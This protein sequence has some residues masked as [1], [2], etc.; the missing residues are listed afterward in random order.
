MDETCQ[1][2][3]AAHRQRGIASAAPITTAE[4]APAMLR[5]PR[6]APIIEPVAPAEIPD[7]PPGS[8]PPA[9]LTLSWTPVS[10]IEVITKL[11]SFKVRDGWHFWSGDPVAVWTNCRDLRTAEPRFSDSSFSSRSTYGWFLE[12]DHSNGNWWCLE[13]NVPYLDADRR[14]LRRVRLGYPVPILVQ[15]F[16]RLKGP[17]STENNTRGLDADASKPIDAGRT[18]SSNPIED[19][20]RTPSSS[21]RAPRI[22]QLA[23]TAEPAD[24]VEPDIPLALPQGD[25]Q[26]AVSGQDVDLTPE[27]SSFDLGRCLTALR[28]GEKHI[29]IRAIQRLHIRWWHCSSERLTALLKSAGVSQDVIKLVPNV[30]SSCKVCRAWTKPTNR[31]VTSSRLSERFG[32]V[33]QVDLLF[34]ES[35]VIVHMIDEATRWSVAEIIESRQAENILRCITDRWIRIFGPMTTLMSDQEGGLV[36]EQASIWAER[37]SIALRFKPKGSHAAIV[38][39]HHQTIRDLYHKLSTQAQHE[40]LTVEPSDILSEAVFAKNVLTNVGGYSPFQALFGRF[41]AVLTDL[42]TAGQSAVDDTSGGIPGASRHAVRLRELAT[43]AMIGA[44]AQARMQIAENSKSRAAGQLH[45]LQPGDAVDV[46]RVPAQKDLSGWRGPAEVLSVRNID[47]GVVDIKWGGRTMS[48]RVQDIRRSALLV[49]FINDGGPQIQCLRQF[50]LQL[51]HGIHTLAWLSLETGWQLS[52]AATEHP[53]E[54]QAVL[55]T[56]ANDLGIRRCI[57]A[58]LGR[59][60]HTLGGLQQVVTSY[61]MWWPAGKPQLYQLLQHAG[62]ETVNLKVLFRHEE[63]S[64]FCWIQYLSVDV[65]NARKL[66]ELNPLRPQ[67]AFDPDDDILPARDPWD[68]STIVGDPDFNMGPGDDAESGGGGHMSDDDDHMLPP[69]WHPPRP[70]QPP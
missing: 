25:G 57:G 60:Y 65:P 70:P 36:S 11:D 39:R 30:V 50:L 18:P 35:L 64:D 16:H 42:E 29:Q 17:A 20:G 37:H 67:L 66:R 9:V 48:A 26:Q 1:W 46:H 44:T 19:A 51:H 49:Y 27:W 56:A 58:R 8:A 4:Q 38:E 34:I 62:S 31:S 5:E 22:P 43:S 47:Q 41:P 24:G 40:R 55:H 53:R 54:F 28:S 12:H 69:M 3:V 10:N 63:W 33:V 2:A 52:H 7:A 68:V 21:S 61:L 14:E 15:V 45:D 23:D 6:V 59:G 13:S 32:E